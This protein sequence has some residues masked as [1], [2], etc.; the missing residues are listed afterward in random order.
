MALFPPRV[1]Q[2]LLL[3]N[4][5]PKVPVYSP[6]PSARRASIVDLALSPTARAAVRL[7]AG[8]LASILPAPL[9]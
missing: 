1:V 3:L 6:V 4:A 2:V 7:L 8:W 9:Q 5:V